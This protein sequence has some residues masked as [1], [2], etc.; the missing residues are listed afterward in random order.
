M[1]TVFRVEDDGRDPRSLTSATRP[2]G[3]RATRASRRSTRPRRSRGSSTARSP[4]RRRTSSGPA[5]S[6]SAAPSTDR[7]PLRR[8]ARGGRRHCQ[9]RQSRPGGRVGRA[10]CGHPRDDLHAGRRADDEARGDAELR[11]AGR[12]G[13]GDVRRRPRR[14][15]RAR[16]LTGATFVHAFDDPRVIAGQGTIGLELAEQIDGDRRR[17]C[18]DRRR[19]A[20]V[21]H[22]DRAAGAA[23]RAPASS[24]SRPAA[25]RA[26]RRARRPSAS[27][28]A[29]GIAV[30][31]AG[32]ADDADPPRPARRDRRRRRRADQRGDRAPAGADEAPGR[33]RGRGPRRGA[34]RRAG[35]RRR[36]GLLRARRREHR[37]VDA[38]L[39]DALRA[40][41]RGP[42]P[43]RCARGSP[44][45]RAR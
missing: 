44:T 6:R 39:G 42:L 37:R 17:S 10:R 41:G 15:T 9:R 25:V 14:R 34:A 1:E 18:P 40:H 32:D 30:K 26:A 8:G 36:A 43:G 19:R 13:G 31:H 45:G 22:R 24:A 5:R 4:S 11:R 35:R 7:H 23:A 12:V 29:D 2:R 33:R 20:R 3:S 27:T 38:R 21:R 28:I 16:A